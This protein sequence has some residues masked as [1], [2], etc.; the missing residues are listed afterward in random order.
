MRGILSQEGES[1]LVDD[2]GLR[3]FF[4]LLNAV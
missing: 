1:L 3:N 4:G 2:G